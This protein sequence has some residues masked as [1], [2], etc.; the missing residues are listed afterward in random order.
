MSDATLD[1]PEC[2]FTG[3]FF[4]I[5]RVVVRVRRAVGIAFKSDCRHGD[6][7]SLKQ[8]LFKVVVLRFSL[9]QVEPPAIVVNDD[10]DVIGVVEGL[11]GAIVGCVVKVPLRR[12]GLPD[13]FVEVVRVL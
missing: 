5:A 9:S 1:N 12:R 6:G 4:A 10:G 7:W 11:R 8:F 3:E 2:I 13:E